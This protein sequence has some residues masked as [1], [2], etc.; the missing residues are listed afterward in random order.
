LPVLFAR[1][2]LPLGAPYKAVL[3]PDVAPLS[4][5]DNRYVYIVNEKNVTERRGVNLGSLQDGLRVVK[6]GL[7]VGDR[8]IVS[9]LANVRPGMTVKPDLVDRKQP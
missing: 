6:E 1:V 5:P 7:S 2:R 4:D 3:I 9:G 8:V